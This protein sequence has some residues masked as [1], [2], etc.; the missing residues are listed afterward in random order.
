[1]VYIINISFWLSQDAIDRNE[2]LLEHL[3]ESCHNTRPAYRDTHPANIAGKRPS[4]T[5]RISPT[6]PQGPCFVGPHYPATPHRGSLL[7]L[8]LTKLT[9]IAGATVRLPCFRASFSSDFPYSRRAPGP[10]LVLYD[11][12]AFTL[13]FE[14]TCNSKMVLGGGGWWEITMT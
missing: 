5:K 8:L 6:R 13:H 11:Q 9:G 4:P 10:T 12:P 1:M 14:F 7:C 2:D 3:G